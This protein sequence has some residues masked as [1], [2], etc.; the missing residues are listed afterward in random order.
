MSEELELATVEVLGALAYG[1]LRSFQVTA[2]AVGHAPDA[3]TADEL[4]ELAL[5]EHAGYVLLRDTLAHRTDLP[6]AVMDRQKPHFDAYFDRVPLDDWFG[7]CAFF[8]LGLPIAADFG[9]ELAASLDRETGMVVVASLADRG[10]FQQ[11]ATD[12][13]RAQL[14]DDETCAR[15]R[16]LVAN[17]LGRALQGFQGVMSDTDALKVVLASG[18]ADGETGET[19]A[20]RLAIGVMQGHHRRMIEL[21]LEDLDE[22]E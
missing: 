4:A 9:R 12:H 5:R 3:R 19:R 18:A 21:G 15:A 8:A 10:P 17:L 20:K 7:A 22:I 13:L 14:G 2:R 16:Q 6:A 11:F 1:Q